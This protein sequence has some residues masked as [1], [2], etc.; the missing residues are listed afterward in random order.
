METGLTEVAEILVRGKSEQIKVFSDPH[1][2]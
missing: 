2:I 1:L